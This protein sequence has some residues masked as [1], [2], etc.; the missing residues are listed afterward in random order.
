M[1]ETRLPVVNDPDY[2]R[3]LASPRERV[4]DTS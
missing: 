1:L 4:R 2:E 3:L